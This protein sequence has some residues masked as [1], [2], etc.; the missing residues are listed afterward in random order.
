MLPAQAMDGVVVSIKPIHSLVA[1]VTKGVST[2]YLLLRGQSSPHTYSLRPSDAKKIRSARLVFWIGPGLETFLA[3]PIK[4]LGKSAKVVT[5][6]KTSGLARLKVRKASDFK[7]T[8]NKDHGHHGHSD[9]HKSKKHRGHGHDDHGHAKAHKPK[10]RAKHGH[11]HHGHSETRK[12]KQHSGHGH[13]HHGHSGNDQHFWLSPNNAQIFVRKIVESLKSAD[14]DNAKIYEKNARKLRLDITAQDQ[15]LSARMGKMK[16]RKF[17]VFHDAYQYFEKRFGLSA[18]GAI[19]VHP[20]VPP[21]AKRVSK[22]RA[23][24]KRTR[25]VCVF[26]E[27][28]F[29]PKIAKL[30]TQGTGAHVAVLDPLGANLKSGPNLYKNLIENIAQSF[31]NCLKH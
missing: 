4:N 27:P 19:I 12:T 28:Q 22:I 1:S 30:V 16:D 15:S 23:M 24:I 8:E 29:N 13:H 10:K 31:E 5:L 21:S 18:T 3:K 6:S 17:F 9:S 14:P 26:S 7:S 11:A 2:P 25:S 20:D